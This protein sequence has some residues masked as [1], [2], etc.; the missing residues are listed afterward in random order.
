MKTFGQIRKELKHTDQPLTV[1]KI[2]IEGDEWKFLGALDLDEDLKD[3]QQL[4]FESHPSG[5][6]GQ[7]PRN[8]ALLLHRLEKLG[9]RMYSA[10]QNPMYLDARLTQNNSILTGYLYEPAFI[11]NVDPLINAEN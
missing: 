6:M 11:K 4:T 7:K 8:L 5:E 3:V 9:F 1:L 10:R 2:D